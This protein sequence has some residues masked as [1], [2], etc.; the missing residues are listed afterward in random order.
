MLFISDIVGEVIQSAVKVGEAKKKAIEEVENDAMMLVTRIDYFPLT[1][2]RKSRQSN[3]VFDQIGACRIRLG[4]GWSKRILGVSLKN[5]IEVKKINEKWKEVG[6]LILSFEVIDDYGNDI[7]YP[8][9]VVRRVEYVDDVSFYNSLSTLMS[10]F[11]E[12]LR[13]CDVSV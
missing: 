5:I 12:G 11:C 9:I 1:K 7:L 13:M 10:Q 6:Q 2:R 3:T 4:Q 8:P